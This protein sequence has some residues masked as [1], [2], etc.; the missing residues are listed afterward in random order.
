MSKRDWRLFVYD[1]LDS[2]RKI[3]TYISGMAYE[4]FLE[5]E[6]TKDAVVRNLEV[7]GEAANKIPEEVKIKHQEIPWRQIIGLRNRL[8][9]GYFVVDYRIVW[10]I[11]TKELYRLKFQLKK[12]L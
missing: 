1:M 4:E 12:L 11:A 9:H 3:E 8:I 7:I 2:I 10:D 6:K 5:D